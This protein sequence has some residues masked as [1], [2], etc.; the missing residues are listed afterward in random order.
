MQFHLKDRVILLNILPTKGSFE[1][2]VV[3]EDIL[4]KIA[5]SQEEIATYDIKTD[6]KGFLTWRQQED[7]F[8]FDFTEL[9]KEYV[10]RVLK[11]QSEKKELSVDA[12]NLFRL[13]I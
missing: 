7:T 4:K 1:D 8:S 11:E 3:R 2:L 10:K 6:S 5:I 9:E 12:I 13:F